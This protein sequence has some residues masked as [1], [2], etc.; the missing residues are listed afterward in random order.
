MSWK[1]GVC[2]TSSTLSSS[3]SRATYEVAVLS[4]QWWQDLSLMSRC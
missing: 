2:M 3:K 1:Y 4:K